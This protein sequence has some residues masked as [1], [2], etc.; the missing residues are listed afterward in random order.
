M[1]QLTSQSLFA[2]QGAQQA[3]RT[4]I[5]IRIQHEKKQAQKGLL[6]PAFVQRE[7]RQ[8]AEIHDDL[9]DLI[10]QSETLLP[11]EALQGAELGFFKCLDIMA[12]QGILS[13]QPTGSAGR[14]LDSSKRSVDRILAQR[15]LNKGSV[16]A[17]T[18]GQV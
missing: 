9:D 13:T 11:N 10:E 18:H 17:S 16:T 1:N 14:L 4:I 2:L 3:L 15:Q 8:L 12:K 5:H 6:V 7:T